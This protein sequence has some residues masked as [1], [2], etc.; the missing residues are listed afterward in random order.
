MVDTSCGFRM[1]LNNTLRKHFVVYYESMKRKLKIKPIYECRCDGRL[2]TSFWANPR[3]VT[4][5][6]QRKKRLQSFHIL[7]DVRAKAL[8]TCHASKSLKSQQP[9]HVAF[10]AFVPH[11][12]FVDTNFVGVRHTGR[13]GTGGRG[14][15]D[16]RRRQ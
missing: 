7:A 3:F 1:D 10:S 9:D 13:S 12:N 4:V 8:C 11:T 15:C 16:K 2:Q 5:T 6:N 14:S